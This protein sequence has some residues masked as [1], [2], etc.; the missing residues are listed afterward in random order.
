MSAATAE[1]LPREQRP[2]IITAGGWARSGKG[3]SMAHLKAALEDLGRDVAHIDQG[4]KFRAMT[5]VADTEGEVTGSPV[6]LNNFLLTS[7]AQE[8]TLALLDDIAEM[9]E[10]E[11]KALLY[12][13]KIS[14]E[15][16]KV[17]AVASSHEI[18]VRLMGEQVARAAE[19]ETDVILIDGRAIEG[20]AR[21]YD[22]AGIAR[23]G[24]SWYFKC[25]PWIAARRSLGLFGDHKAMSPE[26][27]DALLNE[28]ASIS[29]RNRSD[30]QRAVDPLRDPVRAY[31]L[32]LFDYASPDREYTPFKISHDIK[33]RSRDSMA[34]VDTSYT[35]S[36][37]AM[38]GP[39]T[40]LSLF[41]L[42]H[43]HILRPE[44]V[45]IRTVERVEAVE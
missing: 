26:D 44:D 36:I 28:V 7:K 23:F 20:Y 33:H 27:R 25:D 13:Q 24:I 16:R 9:T 15:V 30:M 42:Y 19:D 29:D 3:T 21:G 18:A 40:E 45:G 39:V 32:N 8:A 43:A 38:T 34:M 1:A 2:G 4:L 37:E 31:E 22:E 5:V 41:A 6:S 14:E 11:R 10:A 17:G 35:A 12:S